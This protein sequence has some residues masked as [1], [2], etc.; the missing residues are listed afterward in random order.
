MR[1]GHRNFGTRDR[2]S[3]RIGVRVVRSNA[4]A[5]NDNTPKRRS[6]DPVFI[7]MGPLLLFMVLRMI[8]G[9]F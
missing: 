7:V 5:V 2:V 3:D 9:L 4:S 8:W 6:I 1:N